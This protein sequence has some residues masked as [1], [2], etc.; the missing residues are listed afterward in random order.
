M[1]EHP[2]LFKDEMVRAILDG[3]KTMTRRVVK[4]T[5]WPLVEEVFRVNGQWVFD[6]MDGTIVSPY[7]YPGNRLWV[8]ET[9]KIASFMEGDPMR[10]QYRAD[11]GESEESG[12]YDELKYEEWFERVCVQSTDY[13]DKIK[14][15]NKDDDGV[16]RWDIGKSPL[17]W[18]PS[19]FMPRWANR[20]ILEI[21]NIKVEQLQE[22]TNLGA[23]AEG[24]P[25]LR[26]LENGFDLRD[27]FSVYWHSLNKDNGFRWGAN[28]WVWVI[29]F[30]R[31]TP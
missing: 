24:T 31:I 8:R 2:I 27:C 11:M 20:I 4:P 22:I 10:F 5:M 30:K 1:N 9:W 16:Y 18:R 13:V 17:P 15:P 26:T 6:V 25:D 19:I 29:E 21:V 23:L 28:P 7:G 14:W 12:D 3:R